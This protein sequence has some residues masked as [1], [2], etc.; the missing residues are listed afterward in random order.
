MKRQG[1]GMTVRVGSIWGTVAATGAVAYSASEG[2]V[3]QITRALALDHVWER[4]SNQCGLSRRGR[5]PDVDP[6]AHRTR[7][8][9]IDGKTERLAATAPLGRLA[10]ALEIAR[11]V[12]FL[13]LD[14]AS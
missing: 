9:R 6:R 14:E 2:A 11:V 3:H 12:L 13:A 5:Y 4:H 10:Q 7:N 1:R 8:R